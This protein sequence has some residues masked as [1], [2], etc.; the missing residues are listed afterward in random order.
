M[1]KIFLLA[2]GALGFTFASVQAQE[3]GVGIGLVSFG[4][5]S[6]ENYQGK[7]LGNGF[8][9]RAYYNQKMLPLISFRPEVAYEKKSKD[10]GDYSMINVSGNLVVGISVPGIAEVYG[11]AG[12]GYD[13]IT[14]EPKVGSSDTGNTLVWNALAGAKFSLIPLCSIY[15]EPR[16][17]GIIGEEKDAAKVAGIG[18][19]ELF[20]GVAF[21]F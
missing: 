10:Y 12:I 9:A 16:Y 14:V 6:Y 21:G 11:G 19:F 1:K 3:L 18:R 2:C 20:A 13:F 4:E 5:P 15:V 17:V 8:G 7:D